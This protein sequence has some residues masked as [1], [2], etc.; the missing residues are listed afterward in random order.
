MSDRVRCSCRRCTIRSLMGPAILITI[1]ILFLLSEVEGGNFDFSNTYPVIIIVIGVVS[2]TAALAPMEG[3]VFSSA[4]PPPPPAST[5][6]QASGAGTGTLP[7][8]GG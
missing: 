4:A 6:P 2:L 1:G 5:P 8:Q 7:G 3:H